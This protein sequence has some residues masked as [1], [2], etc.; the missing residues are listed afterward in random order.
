MAVVKRMYANIIMNGNKI[1]AD[2][3]IAKIIVANR[4]MI[5]ISH[6]HLKSNSIIVKM[7]IVNINIVL[8]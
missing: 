7:K 1:Y 6:V 5:L 3:K 4:N 2:F 8:K